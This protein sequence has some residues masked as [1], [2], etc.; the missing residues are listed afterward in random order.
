MTTAR[1]R[2]AL[3]ISLGAVA[4]VAIAWQ[5]ARWAQPR[6]YELKSAVVTRLDAT[7]RSGEIQFIHPKSGRTMIVA[8]DHIPEDCEILINGTKATL[9]DVRVGDHVA[10]RGLV[11]PRDRAVM[12]YW[13][14]VT[15]SEGT[16]TS[17]AATTRPS[18]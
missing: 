17:G 14:H 15:R 6:E 16:P 12:P 18:P 3:W 4:V 1:K 10:V 5:A 2:V 11:N 9:A 13:V 7:T 8:A